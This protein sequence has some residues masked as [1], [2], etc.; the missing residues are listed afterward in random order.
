MEHLLIRIGR[1]FLFLLSLNLLFGNIS[2]LTHELSRLAGFLVMAVIGLSYSGEDLH[3]RPTLFF[4]FAGYGFASLLIFLGDFFPAGV[5][6]FL[7]L[8]LR[9]KRDLY[10]AEL[11]LFLTTLFFYTLFHYVDFCFPLLFQGL[12]A[13]AIRY[14]ELVTGWAGNPMRLGSSALGMKIT[15]SALC[16]SVASTLSNPGRRN[17]I[18]SLAAPFLANFLF[19]VLQK[20]LST[21]VRFLIKST[22]IVPF[23]THVVLILFSV[24]M[25]WPFIQKGLSKR[26]YE[27]TFARTAIFNGI[28]GGVLVFAALFLL[29]IAPLGELRPGAILFIDRGTDFQVPV[30]GKLYGKNGPGMFGILPYYLKMRG[31]HTKIVREKV[32]GSMLSNA[33]ALVIF[34][35]STGFSE[36]ERDQIKRFVE[37]GGALLVAGDH[38]DVNGVM[39]PLN[40][41]LAPFHIQLNFDTA[42]PL[43]SGWA[44]SLTLWNHPVTAGLSSYH[45]TGVWVGA[46]L[47]LSYPAIPLIA[48]KLGWA[49]TGNYMNGKRAYLG[50]YIRSKDEPLGDVVLAAESRLKK[51]TVIVFGDTSTFQ[52][53]IIPETSPF[54]DRIILSLLSQQPGFQQKIFLFATALLF[55]AGLF[56]IFPVYRD[57]WICVVMLFAIPLSATVTSFV[58]SRFVHPLPFAKEAFY[59]PAW[60]DTSHIPKITPLASADESV[61]GITLNL[62]R[63]RMIPLYLKKMDA[64][65][66]STGA[67]LFML[68][69]TKKISEPETRL[70]E[71]YMKRGGVIVWAVGWEEGGAS[72]DFLKRYRLSLDAVPLGPCEASLEQMNIRFVDAWPIVAKEKNARILVKKWTYP[73]VVFQPVGKGGLLLI[74]DSEFLLSQNLESYKTFNI[75]NIRFFGYLVRYLLGESP[76][77]VFREKEGAGG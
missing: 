9:S 44:E 38:T 68:S 76:Q 24:T 35:P 25:A 7:F 56:L 15:I 19:L 51:G 58:N 60:I 62:M 54:I 1:V 33:S 14:S 50:D 30:Y 47:K 13:I 77:S 11:R 42:L 46:S 72:A 43:K 4:R 69:P 3:N 10:G 57:P 29:M 18:F 12:N 2:Y 63:N 39:K 6:G 37:E 52:N 41:L 26:R 49:D 34:N 23:H 48:G 65:L 27:K 28:T 17:T 31:F 59:R 22:E 75:N 53:G 40:D 70:L 32:T 36:K 55:L 16:L 45:E 71:D 21:V 66:L 74:G 20:P 64:S 67:L 61:W 8:L 73:V 5:A